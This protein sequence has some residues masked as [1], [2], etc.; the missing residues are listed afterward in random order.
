MKVKTVVAIIVWKTKDYLIFPNSI[1]IS[2]VMANFSHL[3]ILF[4]M[5]SIGFRLLMKS[6]RL[7]PSLASRRLVKRFKG[8]LIEFCVTEVGK[9]DSDYGWLEKRSLVLKDPVFDEN[10]RIKEKG[11]LLIKF[12]TTFPNAFSLMDL[13]KLEKSFIVVL[14]PSWSGYC[15]PEILAWCS[16]KN[17]VIVQASERRDRELISMLDSNLVPVEFGSGDWVDQEVFYPLENVIKDIDVVYVA[18][19]NSIKRQYVF[20][21]VLKRLSDNGIRLNAALVCGAWGECKNEILDLKNSLGLDG[22]VHFYEELSQDEL[23]RLLNRSKVNILLSLKEGSNRSL[24]E[25]F[26]SNT[27]GIV[28]SNNIGVNKSYFNNM[29]GMCVSEQDLPKA[30]LHFKEFWRNYEPRKWAMENICPEKTVKKLEK[31]IAEAENIVFDDMKPLAIKVNAPEAVLKANGGVC[32][33]VLSVAEV[34]SEH[35]K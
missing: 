34:I 26:F 21:R 35:E 1:F 31:V 17:T 7:G 8:E 12:T 30:L 11:V 25:G 13:E 27:P 10:K 24:F 14:E 28:L 20:L 6:D 22:L 19:F 9:L 18:N 32:T 29:T 3:M 15:L 5:S 4:G 2:G 33:P 16:L 23:N